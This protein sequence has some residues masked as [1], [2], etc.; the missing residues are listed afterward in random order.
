[1][2]KRKFEDT[3]AGGPL[4]G[5]PG[6][7]GAGGPLGGHPP[8]DTFNE[9]DELAV[10]LAIQTFLWRQT[11]PFIRPKMGRSYDS[12]Q[13]E[14]REACKSFEKVLVQNIQFGLSPSLTA[15]I[16]AIG[17]WRLVKAALPHVLHCCAALLHGRK[18]ACLE[19]LGSAETKLLYTLHWIVLDAC[20]E[21][22]EGLPRSQV[23]PNVFP[24]TV[25]QVFV[26]LFAPL[27]TFLKHSDLMGSFRL[28]NGAKIWLPLWQYKHPAVESF[29]TPVLPNRRREQRGGALGGHSGHRR[30]HGDVVVALPKKRETRK[31]TVHLEAGHDGGS[32]VNITIE[33]DADEQKENQAGPCGESPIPPVA[34]SSGQVCDKCH[35]AK[36]SADDVP[37]APVCCCV[38]GD[39]PQHCPLD[40]PSLATYLDVSVLRC[41]FISQWL[42]EGVFWALRFVHQRLQ[43][44]LEESA[45]EG[46][47]RRRSCSLP[48]AQDDT[49]TPT[50]HMA[51]YSAHSG[52]AHLAGHSGLGG[53][54]GTIGGLS[55]AMGTMG[56]SGAQSHTTTLYPS[57][58]RQRK[59][60]SPH[61]PSASRSSSHYGSMQDLRMGLNQINQGAGSSRAS[62]TRK[63]G[64]G[65]FKK[66]SDLR[67]FVEEHLHLPDHLDLAMTPALH[68]PKSSLGL[69]TEQDL[70]SN[71]LS[72]PPFGSMTRGKSLPSIHIDVTA[73]NDTAIRDDKDRLR[74]RVELRRE[75]HNSSMEHLQRPS[76][77]PPTITVTEH[78]PVS[79]IQ[80][81]LNQES[82][83]S[84]KN[85]DARGA[86][87]DQMG[88]GSL[89]YPPCRQFG[90]TRSQTDSDIMYALEGLDEA[91]GSTHYITAD[92][93]IHLQVVLKAVH[94]V[95]L[96]DT[97]CSLRVCEAILDIL[98]Q[99]LQMHVLLSPNSHGHA[100]G[101]QE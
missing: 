82:G 52:Y 10:P 1:M 56:M 38:R 40:D 15:A 77:A 12:S 7:I 75:R 9:P 51:H 57:P 44:I 72:A 24:I 81:F 62:S 76:A 6:P 63:R 36:A 13:M 3:T 99:L 17:R 53:M 101:Q 47:S 45:R 37:G 16:K 25:I 35:L 86:L 64:P 46:F 60:Q 28:E 96:R 71:S 92:G 21:C 90:I 8:Y 55:M 33:S 23:Q 79:S 19:K 78:S 87:E 54:V 97:A 80:F 74:D 41:L 4:G 67:S 29:T 20:Q 66:G 61:Y 34:D 30:A 93:R 18:E 43:S 70:A 89:F 98:Q 50:H 2:P 26:Y 11:S 49:M 14:Q 94:A 58:K 91:S 39:L 83:D 65:G 85:E 42:E 22:Q 88:R 48:V 27:L 59:S 31:N 68:R 84:P 69:R 95:T 100:S 5:H 73:Q 32:T